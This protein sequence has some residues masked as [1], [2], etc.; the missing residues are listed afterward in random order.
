MT[1]A[2][3]KMNYLI[4][5]AVANVNL[6]AVCY[7]LI[8]TA[9]VDEQ[10]ELLEY[11]FVGY[12]SIPTTEE[13]KLPKTIS[14]EDERKY[15]LHYGK[16]VDIHMEELQKQNLFEKDFYS[17]LWAFIFES[18]VFPNE[19]ARI[20]ALFDCAIDKR[21]PYFKLDRDRAL[22]MENEEYRK[23]CA[24]I[25]DDMFAKLGFILNANFDQ[26]TEQASLVVQMMDKMPDYIQ[27][28]VFLTRV[29]AHYKNEILRLLQLKISMDALTDD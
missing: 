27:R 17:Q 6:V 25:G 20:I 5:N 11:F 23:I 4:S 7:Q 29:I 26:K 3:E 21:L 16:L 13:L 18:P 1:N 10:P 19:K 12:K 9:P 24:Q 22:S 14:G 8:K 2:C 28:C 15:M